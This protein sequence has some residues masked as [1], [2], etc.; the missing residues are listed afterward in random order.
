MIVGTVT[1]VGPNYGVIISVVGEVFKFEVNKFPQAEW[2]QGVIFLK[3]ERVNST[4][5][6]WARDI[7]R[8][9]FLLEERDYTSDTGTEGSDGKNKLPKITKK[10]HMIFDRFKSL[11]KLG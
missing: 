2:G 1:N 6:Q 7:S 9:D 4:S 11:F 10:L 3:D 5:E 8:Y